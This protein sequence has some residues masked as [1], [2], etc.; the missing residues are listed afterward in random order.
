MATMPTNPCA[1]SHP[2]LA[3]LIEITSL[4]DRLPKFLCN[5]CGDQLGFEQAVRNDE[6][7]QLTAQGWRPPAE[8]NEVNRCPECRLVAAHL[9]LCSRPVPMPWEA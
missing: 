3:L 4:S 6:R 9:P 1:D 7:L 8:P 5:R 2:E